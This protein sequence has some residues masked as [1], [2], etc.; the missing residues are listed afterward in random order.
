MIDKNHPINDMINRVNEGKLQLGEAIDTAFMMDIWKRFTPTQKKEIVD[1]FN[2]NL[3]W[4]DLENASNAHRFLFI[5]SGLKVEDLVY[6]VN[7]KESGKI[8]K[9]V[10]DAYPDGCKS[11][12]I[13]NAF[14]LYVDD[15]M[16]GQPL[17]EEDLKSIVRYLERAISLIPD[18]AQKE[19]KEM[20]Y[21]LEHSA[22][23]ML[24]EK[25]QQGNKSAFHLE[26]N[27]RELIINST[28]RLRDILNRLSPGEDPV[29]WA[30]I[31]LSLVFCLLYENPAP[32]KN[33]DE[34]LTLCNSMLN[35][36]VEK[37][38]DFNWG[39]LYH[40]FGMIYN[41]YPGGD[42]SKN[43][44]KSI[45]SYEKA[46]QYRTRESDP[47]NW[48]M[49][50]SNLGNS[51][52]DLPGGDFEDNINS[53]IE[54]YEN[55][56]EV[57]KKNKYP[58]D[59]AF[60]TV[61]LGVAYSERGKIRENIEDLKKAETCYKEALS[62]F[63]EEVNP[64]IYYAA[65]GNLGANYLFI[66]NIDRDKGNL[67][68]ARDCSN[69]IPQ[70]VK[71][72]SPNLYV[73]SRLR[74]INLY[75]LEADSKLD[76]SIDNLLSQLENTFKEEKFSP[77][78]YGFYRSQ[79]G[80]Y[81]K[82]RFLNRELSAG[83]NKRDINE[84]YKKAVDAL[85]EAME[86]YAGLKDFSGI[87][88]TCD[89]LIE[90]YDKKGMIAEVIEMCKYAIDITEKA[91]LYKVVEDA[92][93][94][95][96]SRNIRFYFR[97][98][99]LYMDQGSPVKALQVADRIKSRALLAGIY[100]RRIMPDDI[101]AREY[102]EE[103]WNLIS[104]QRKLL[105]ELSN[106][107]EVRRSK[108]S[109]NRIL[110][111]DLRHLA[112]EPGELDARIDDVERK[113][114]HCLGKLVETDPKY[115]EQLHGYKFPDLDDFFRV[116]PDTG[117]ITFQHSLRGVYFL[118]I[119]ANPS[120]DED[121]YKMAYD[122]FK[123]KEMEP[124]NNLVDTWFKEY[125]QFKRDPKKRYGYER[126]KNRLNVMLTSYGEIIGSRI[127]N[128]FYKKRIKHLIFV[129]NRDNH[130]IPF[131]AIRISERLLDDSGKPKFL[132]ELFDK[133]T[134]L[135][136]LAMVDKIKERQD[137]KPL[138]ITAATYSP[139]K[140]PL[141]HCKWELAG[142]KSLFGGNIKKW[143]GSTDEISAFIEYANQSD[144][145]HISA[146]GLTVI[147]DYHQ[148]HILLGDKIHFTYSDILDKIKL[149]SN[150]LVTLG[151]CETGYTPNRVKRTAWDEY[152][153]IDSAFLQVGAKAVISS[154][155]LADD[156]VTA[157]LMY[158]LYKKIKT[159]NMS[160]ADALCDA[161]RNILNESW[162]SDGTIDEFNRFFIAH[163]GKVKI[164]EL[165][166]VEDFSHPMEWANFKYLGIT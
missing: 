165:S 45:D 23:L 67:S 105:S 113:L 164:S 112:D 37:L 158:L 22:N 15:L 17:G 29:K 121:G 2:E 131:S 110:V 7:P 115:V 157:L 26:Y 77:V 156:R 10:L 106:R 33:L 42:R 144:I 64:H 150:S 53:A 107:N 41:E 76:D 126:V 39:L 58:Y 43:M 101:A 86:T 11:S 132:I 145:L 1:Y 60:T 27:P 114:S 108:I 138:K 75:L 92:K 81:W 94:F 141:P 109:L 62:I 96:M 18:S 51:R 93:S 136:N 147:V 9:I 70:N 59:W 65:L 124:L 102:A 25:L 28:N 82:Q 50:Q 128:D 90:I 91:R 13:A 88:D 142:I 152:V 14:R 46:L 151:S 123:Y 143:D 146:H 125:D 3:N 34:A 69:K 160:P 79:V 21:L 100:D 140:N 38:P 116:H 153:G 148:S 130:L 127:I 66:Y 52:M 155:W 122:F 48:A 120:E 83:K 85:K 159:E 63:K 133:I 5:Y 12:I 6:H 119:S 73:R 129:S 71:E 20:I 16:S 139:P 4:N 118:Y 162:K 55:A 87:L 8:L 134:I 98:F 135:P 35:I 137:R 154:I 30:N 103:Y 78:L 84:V 80:K 97:L 54:C 74:L 104:Q 117:F 72:L 36:P 111:P 56:L 163:P 95:E 47:Y 99:Q 89:Q 61:L 32:E 57:R 44:K 24:L 19:L 49:T 166:T 68:K 149:T 161:Q 31:A 40:S